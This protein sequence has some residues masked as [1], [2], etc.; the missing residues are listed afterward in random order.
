MSTQ[1]LAILFGSLTV[2]LFP[3]I[4]SQFSRNSKSADY[5][6]P[7]E[8]LN[9]W[10]YDVHEWFFFHPLLEIIDSNSCKS[11]VSLSR[12]QWSDKIHPHLC[13]GHDGGIKCMALKENFVDSLFS[14]MLHI[15]EL[16]PSHLCLW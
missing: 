13:N 3:I 6:L 5:V 2:E 4:D 10:C 1:C 14:G 9:C 16:A 12:W 11:A 8:L 15:A 7:E